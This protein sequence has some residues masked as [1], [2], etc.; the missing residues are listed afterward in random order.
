[1]I[2]RRKLLAGTIATSLCLVTAAFST[3]AAQAQEAAQQQ[4]TPAAS[5]GKLIATYHGVLPCADCPGIDTTLKLFGVDIQA[6]HGVYTTKNAYQERKTSYTETGTW[7]LEKGTPADASA[8]VYVLKAKTGNGLTNFLRVNVNEIKQLDNDR[9]P[10]SGTVNFSLK[11]VPTNA[12][13][14]GSPAI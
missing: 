6:T 3:A 8:S 1:M 10:F 13:Q 5:Q 14:H 11:R 7:T 9:K 12:P 2:F 4:T